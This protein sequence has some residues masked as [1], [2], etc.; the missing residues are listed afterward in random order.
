[1]PAPSPALPRFVELV[2]VSSQGQAARDTPEDQRVALE[3]L[4]ASRPGILVER[5]EVA[6][7]VSGALPAAK[8]PDLRRLA[9]LARGRAFDEVRVRHLDRLTRHEDLRERAEIYGALADAGAIIVDGGGHVID[10]ASEVG[11]IDYVLQTWMA[12][13]ERRRI[14]ERTLTAKRRL[15]GEGRLVGG[16]TPF[17]RTWNRKKGWGLDREAAAIYRRM[18]ELCLTG[19]TLRGIAASLNAAGA[20]GPSGRPWTFARI[21]KLLRSPVAT[22]AYATHGATMRIPAIVDEPTWRAAGE[23]LRGNTCI[24]GPVAKH[25]ALLRKLITCGECGRPLYVVNGGPSG[26]KRLYYACSSRGSCARFH[27]VD[28]VDAAV[29]EVLERFLRRPAALLAA[30]ERNHPEDL[31]AEAARSVTA[32]QGELR[33]LDRQEERIARLLRRRLLSPRVGEGQLAEVARLRAAADEELRQ[34][35][36]RQG[37]AAHAEEAAQEIEARVAELRRNLG[38]RTFADWRELCELLFPRSSTWWV[39]I[40]ADGTLRLRPRL[41]LDGAGE[42]ALTRMGPGVGPSPSS[43]RGE[44]IRDVPV[45]LVASVARGRTR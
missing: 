42:A 12:A 11:E 29:R 40:W 45:Q 16:R 17:G 7:G 39:R 25:P 26:Y 2:R 34:A 44:R 20:L 3:R 23:R 41:A 8:R 19:R 21:A 38:R 22:G 1:M 13:R 24:S 4:R 10:P 15:A 27:R 30:A 18:F 32:A 37:A 33:D 6:E 9:E 43:G 5:I 35:E 36:A 14:M 31:A 28:R